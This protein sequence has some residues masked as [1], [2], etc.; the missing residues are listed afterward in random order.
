MW[1]ENFFFLYTFFDKLVLRVIHTEVPIQKFLDPN[2]S[3]KFSVC[4]LLEFCFINYNQCS[5]HIHDVRSFGDLDS[6][7]G[8]GQIVLKKKHAQ[9][10][11]KIRCNKKS[12]WTFKIFQVT[13]DLDFTEFFLPYLSNKNLSTYDVRTI[14][15]YL[16]IINSN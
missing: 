7:Q 2:F 5:A 1:S 6:N 8:K 12:D 10:L 15:I 14:S 16:L 11:K 3:M 9:N 13:L 4:P